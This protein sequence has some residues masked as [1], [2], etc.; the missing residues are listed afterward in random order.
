MDTNKACGHVASFQPISLQFWVEKN[1]SF[2][3]WVALN[4]VL[5]WHDI[6]MQLLGQNL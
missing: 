3:C 4:P 5:I 1:L 6:Q 2:A